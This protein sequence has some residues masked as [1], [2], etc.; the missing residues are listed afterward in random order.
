MK[1]LVLPAAL[2]LA[3]PLGCTPAWWQLLKALNE[4]GTDVI[5]TPY[6]GRPVT[7]LWWRCYENPGYRLG[8]L[9]SKVT[10][11]PRRRRTLQSGSARKELEVRLARSLI[12]SR[13]IR[14]LSSII[15]AEGDVSALVILTAPPNHLAGVGAS[16]RERFRIPV[17]YYDADLPTSLSTYGGFDSGVDRYRGARLAEYDLV[18]SNSQ[19]VL[20]ELRQMGARRADV[21]WFAADPDIFRPMKAEEDIDVFFYGHGV[22]QRE[23]YLRELITIPSERLPHRRFVVAGT[24]LHM[25]LGKAE[26]L[27]PISPSELR[28]M[29]AR[30]RIQVN[31]SRSP[32]ATV[33]ASSNTRLFELAAMEEAIVTNPL[34]GIEEWFRPGS[35]L[36]VVDSSARAVAVYEDLIADPERRRTLAVGARRRVLDEHTFRHRAI[37]LLDMLNSVMIGEKP[38][39]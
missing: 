29:I 5:A 17:C 33:Y 16:I 35:E 34:N 1:L 14:H 26:R 9:Y 25:D 3:H 20:D 23:D 6:Y 19:G 28:K 24:H 10:R 11:Y 4:C 27:G 36:E 39:T 37:R 30:T 15:E 7:S 2:D 13:W 8:K 21:L 38:A 31:V 22:E 18:L 32:H 12:A